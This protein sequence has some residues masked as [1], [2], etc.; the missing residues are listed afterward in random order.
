MLKGKSAEYRR[1]VADA[2]HAALVEIIGIPEDD[3]FQL[4]DEYDA[5]R[6]IYD[7]A[8]L[9]IERTDEII[10]IRITLRSGRSRETRAALHQAIAQKLSV[11]TGVR[12]EDVFISLVEN[13]YADWSVGRGE[14]PLL[15]LLESN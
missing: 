15:K 10:I 12:S 14:A 2:V 9:G 11:S 13:D 5:D 7:R 4:I 3:R 6:L 1:A 8:Y